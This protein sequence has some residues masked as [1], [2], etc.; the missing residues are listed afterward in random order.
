MFLSLVMALVT[1]DIPYGVA[2]SGKSILWCVDQL[3]LEFQQV[4]DRGN[5][6]RSLLANT[7]D[8]EMLTS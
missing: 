3:L 6:E 1:F 4:G 7:S 8:V 2:G 5:G